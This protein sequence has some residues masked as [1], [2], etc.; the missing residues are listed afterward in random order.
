MPADPFGAAGNDGN[1]AVDPSH[2]AT[3]LVQS[4]F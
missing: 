4:C 1:A 2:N 3:L